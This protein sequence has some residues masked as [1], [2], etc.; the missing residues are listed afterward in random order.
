MLN[1]L[2]VDNSAISLLGICKGE[3]N[4]YVHPKT[5]P[6]TALFIKLNE[7]VLHLVITLIT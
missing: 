2:L 6:E 5:W 1:I 4:V 3:M 7:V